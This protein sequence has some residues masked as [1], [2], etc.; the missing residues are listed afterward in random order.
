MVILLLRA[1][2]PVRR[3][4]VLFWSLILLFPITLGEGATLV[5]FNC[6]IIYHDGVGASSGMRVS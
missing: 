6:H 3:N 4:C 5:F 2:H 1:Q